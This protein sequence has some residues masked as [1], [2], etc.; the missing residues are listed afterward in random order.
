MRPLR[1][2][3]SIDD[4]ILARLAL[5]GRP[6]TLEEVL[7]WSSDLVDVIVQDEFTHDVIL[8]EPA[9]RS[10]AAAAPPRVFVVFDTT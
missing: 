5:A 6:D 2:V 3:G 10:P 4:A 7:R 1:P 9:P 8:R